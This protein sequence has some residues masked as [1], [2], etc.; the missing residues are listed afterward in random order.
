MI[1]QSSASYK[2]GAYKKAC[3]IVFWSFFSYVSLFFCLFCF[4]MILSK[5]AVKKEVEG[6]QKKDMKEGLAKEGQGLSV[7]GGSNLLHTM[8]RTDTVQETSM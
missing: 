4:S 6:G 7:Q 1:S 8:I 3:N 2:S 5:N